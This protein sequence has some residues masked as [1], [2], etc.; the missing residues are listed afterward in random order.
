MSVLRHCIACPCLG[1]HSKVAIATAVCTLR[2]LALFVRAMR[3][4]LV[5]W[6]RLAARPRVEVGDTIAS[7]CD[8]REL[9]VAVTAI[10]CP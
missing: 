9:A 10:G 7:D 8:S 5:A 4:R 6:L 2:D 3:T 1:C